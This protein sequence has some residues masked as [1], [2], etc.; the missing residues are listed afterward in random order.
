MRRVCLQAMSG[1]PARAGAVTERGESTCLLLAV[2]GNG[3]ASL[4]QRSLNT[5]QEFNGHSCGRVSIRAEP[6]NAL[7]VDQA[8]PTSNT[9]NRV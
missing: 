6:L 5:L 2:P 4:E 8:S 7:T 1:S 3:D 9:V